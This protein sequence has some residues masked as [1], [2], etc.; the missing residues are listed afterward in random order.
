MPD[1]GGI[2]ALDL[3]FSSTG[4]A[5]SDFG[6]KPLY[7]SWAL[8]KLADP[9]RAYAVLEDEIFDAIA[10]HG[11]RA[12]VYE[13]PLP[14]NRPS[15]VG[16]NTRQN[17]DSAIGMIR[18][19]GIVEMAAWRMSIRCFH[20]HCG[21][22]RAAVLGKAPIGKTEH[23]KGVIMDW[24]KRRGWTPQCDDEADA[25]LLLQHAAVT[26]DRTNKAHFNRHGIEI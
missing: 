4:W 13:A 24:A 17:N 15:K 1:R 22:A 16:E 20:Q 2:L 25:L 9:G 18:L 14:T 7:G 12:I 3:S 19:G 6:N 8:G 23:V 10:M 5:Y 26:M 11:P 21:Q